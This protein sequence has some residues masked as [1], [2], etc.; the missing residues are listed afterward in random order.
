MSDTPHALE[1]AVSELKEA[2]K[3]LHLLAESMSVISASHR[4]QTDLK[5]IEIFYSTTKRETVFGLIEEKQASLDKAEETQRLSLQ[6]ASDQRSR[7]IYAKAHGE[8]KA[9]M[10]FTDPH[11]A[12]EAH[13]RAEE[14]IM[15]LRNA[16]PVLFR[17]YNLVKHA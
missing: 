13:K 11:A 6:R 10:A 17:V 4:I 9:E 12:K 14:E 7:E 2:F 16:H 8:D 15:K 5:L 3:P 1:V